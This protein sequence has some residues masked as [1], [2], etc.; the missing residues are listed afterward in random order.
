M[1]Q[2]RSLPSRG[3]VIAGKYAIV[4][5]LGE[6]GM[7]VVFEAT[8]VRLQQRVAVK[9]LLPE[10][11]AEEVIVTRFER[12]AR[13]AA[14]LRGR[15]VAS[16]TDVDVT[17]DG[18]PYMV[19]ELLEGHDL[20][21]EL[22]QRGRLPVEYAVDYV[23][24]ACAAMVEAHGLGI[25]H[26]D[27]KP[28]N[29]F[30]EREGDQCVVKVLDFGISKVESEAGVKL[31]TA[32]TVM[33]TAL[34]MSPEQVRS[35]RSVDARSD[36]W[37]LGVIL[38][39]LLSGQPPWLGT[40]TQLAAAIVTEDPP[41][42]RGHCDVPEGLAAIVHRCLRRDVNERFSDVVELAL[43]LAPYAPPAGLGRAFV[44]SLS[45]QPTSTG[46]L[47]STPR[48]GTAV[49]R[50]HD[51]SPEAATA[52]G[53]TQGAGGAARRSRTALAAVVVAAALAVVVG[54]VALVPR[55]SASA[56]AEPAAGSGSPATPATSEEPVAAPPLELPSEVAIVEAPPSPAVTVGAAPTSS[57]SGSPA[58]TVSTVRARPPRAGA[59]A[60]PA[61][62]SSGSQ[63]SPP[64]KK[65]AENPLLL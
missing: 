18:L 43:A 16:V 53:W 28:S 6:G 17:S 49:A 9:M 64:A 21:T 22:E 24:Q 12:E 3:D 56:S 23:L 27:L 36:I 29:L 37:S 13:A 15:H 32:E 57:A 46:A 54:G 31:T 19:M 30:V 63:S 1:S 65:P 61:G 42:L 34:Y 50:M 44:E 11:V 2:V 20:Q 7:G 41:E 55:L 45:R 60:A 10:M 8:H 52:P 47:P 25:V 40:V 38:Y 26:R 62:K 5:V 59:T 48:S 33:G 58:A 51:V 14:Q 35:S 4:R 39:E